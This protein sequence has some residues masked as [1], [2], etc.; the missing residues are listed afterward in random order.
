MRTWHAWDRSEIDEATMRADVG[1]DRQQIEHVLRCVALAAPS[2]RVRR[3][4]MALE[5]DATRMWAFLNIAGMPPT[6]NA[7][8]RALRRAVLWRKRSNGTRVPAGSRYA[9]RILTVVETMRDK[10]GALQDFLADAYTAHVN[11]QPAP[12]LLR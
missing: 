1:R 6:N 4:A 7:A 12:S 3:Q 10:Q 11:Q 9:E 8:E 5:S 2:H